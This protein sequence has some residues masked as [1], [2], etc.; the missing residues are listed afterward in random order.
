MVGRNA[1]PLREPIHVE[2]DYSTA[3]PDC[4]AFV[5]EFSTKDIHFRRVDVSNMIILQMKLVMISLRRDVRVGRS[6]TAVYRA[7][8]VLTR[9]GY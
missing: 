7:R 6:S 2:V 3:A 4:H 9:L 1:R 8:K 5:C